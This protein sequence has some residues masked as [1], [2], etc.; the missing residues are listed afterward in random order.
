L[1]FASGPLRDSIRVFT[2]L[3]HLCPLRRGLG[4][5]FG[6]FVESQVLKREFVGT[7]RVA[8]N[9]V[10]RRRRREGMELERYG[11]EKTH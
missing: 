6:S 11:V 1:V 7:P 2:I 10:G 8:E 9:G 3:D 4:R 5:E